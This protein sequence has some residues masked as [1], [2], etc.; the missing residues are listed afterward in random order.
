[1]YLKEPE[2]SRG[3]AVYSVCMTWVAQSVVLWL[4]WGVV[5]PEQGSTPQR[6]QQ[7]TRMKRMRLCMCNSL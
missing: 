3:E 7:Q 1:M 6:Q 5:E 2:I 4:V